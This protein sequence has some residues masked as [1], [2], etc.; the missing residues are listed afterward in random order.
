MGKLKQPQEV[1]RKVAAVKLEALTQ[2]STSGPT[3]LV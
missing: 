2:P 1:Y 3:D